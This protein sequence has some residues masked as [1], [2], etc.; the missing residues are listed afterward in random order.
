[1][2]HLKADMK[3]LSSLSILFFASLIIVLFKELAEKENNHS[4]LT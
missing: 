4:A 1:M 3:F 2:I